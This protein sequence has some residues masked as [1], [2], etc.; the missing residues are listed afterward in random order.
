M[1]D[2]TKHIECIDDLYNI[3]NT[4]KHL[5]IHNYTDLVFHSKSNNIFIIPDTITSIE[6]TTS[7]S[8]HNLKLPKFLL[9]FKIYMH[10]SFPLENISFPN[11]IKYIKIAGEFNHSIDN[12]KFPDSL[13]ELS[14]DSGYFNQP[15]DNVKFPDSLEKL[16][17][18]HCFDQPIDNVKFPDSLKELSIIGDFN[19]SIN[20]VNFPKSLK[21]LSFGMEYNQTLDKCNFPDDLCLHFDHINS[22]TINSLPTNLKYLEIDELRYPLSNLPFLLKKVTVNWINKKTLDRSK[23]PYGTELDVTHIIHRKDDLLGF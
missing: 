11:T 18:G 19:Y 2:T 4:I 1:C 17:I 22:N 13:K 5:I 7:M 10:Y 6:I 15:I 16:S 14:I 20:N 21:K 12:V 3:P 23:I 8:I 9:V